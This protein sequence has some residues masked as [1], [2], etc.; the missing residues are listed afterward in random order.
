MWPKSKCGQSQSKKPAISLKRVE[1]SFLGEG[2]AKAIW[3]E[4][5]TDKARV[6]GV[7]VTKRPNAQGESMI[8][9]KD[10]GHSYGFGFVFKDLNFSLKRG[11]ALGLLGKNGVGKSSVINI[12]M[13]QIKPTLGSC[14]VCG[15]ESFALSKATRRRIGLL[16]EGHVSYCYLPIKELL[17]LWQELYGKRFRQDLF[18]DLFSK[19]NV[20]LKQRLSSLSCGQRSQVVLALI[21]AQDPELLILDD[22]SLGLDA[23]YRRLFIDYLKDFMSQGDRTLLMT[24]HIVNDLEGLLDDLL[25]LKSGEEALNISFERF[26]REFKGFALDRSVDISKLSGLCSTLDL[27]DER[28]VFGFLDE[29]SFKLKP[30]RRLELSFED[31]F[32]GY[33]GRY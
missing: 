17:G 29:S 33:T 7:I 28:Q 22:Y 31:A 15:E 32:I 25:L 4:A 11:R 18:M 1:V 2:E 3:Q 8:A 23:G 27:K 12:L 30:A 9:V 6:Q 5:I 19:L 10:L 20:S 13:G 16:F 21:L 24:T 14:L 26:R